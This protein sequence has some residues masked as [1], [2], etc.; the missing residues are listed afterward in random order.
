[1]D[2]S[3]E[4]IWLICRLASTT[5]PESDEYDEDF[6]QQVLEKYERR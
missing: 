2:D 5:Q 6:R 3:F 1:M 4:N